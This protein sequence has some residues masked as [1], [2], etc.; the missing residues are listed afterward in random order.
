MISGLTA[1]AIKT[2][3]FV[4]TNGGLSFNSPI[5]KRAFTISSNGGVTFG[6]LASATTHIINGLTTFNSGI[7]GRLDLAGSGGVYLG[8]SNTFYVGTSGTWAFI[9]FS[10]RISTYTDLRIGNGSADNVGGLLSTIMAGDGTTNVL[11]IRNQTTAQS[12]RVY[13]TTNVTSGNY[14]APTDFERVELTWNASGN[15]E[16][17][18]RTISGGTGSARGLII[19][20]NDIDRITVAASGDIT[21]ADGLAVNVGTTSGTKFGTS[22]GQKIGFWGASPVIRPA[23]VTAPTGGATVDS[24]C[25]TSLSDLI[26]KL[27]A[28]GLIS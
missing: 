6:N 15:F 22:G 18:L 11:C 12:F 26:T 13:R 28:I 23:A 14:S 1:S 20:T 19:R 8:N 7:T 17:I 24:E 9:N 10:G 16:A 21:I 25:R 3:T 5:F 4:N 2:Q 27:Q